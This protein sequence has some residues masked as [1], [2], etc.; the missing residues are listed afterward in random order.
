MKK[1][2][3]GFSVVEAFIVVLIITIAG[4]TGYVAYRRHHPAAT[5]NTLDSQPAVTS[6]TPGTAGDIDTINAGDEAAEEHTDT[7]YSTTEQ[8]NATSTDT[9]AAGIGGAYDE[10]SL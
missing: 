9:A 8:Q 4:G 6:A 2:I 10:S 7:T 5:A 3:D 1:A